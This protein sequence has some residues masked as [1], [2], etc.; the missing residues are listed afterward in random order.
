MLIPRQRRQSQQDAD[1]DHEREHDPERLFRFLAAAR[2]QLG[3]DATEPI[4]L[5]L[6]RMVPRKGV[7]TVIRS[8]ASL[9][10]RAGM[11]LDA[12]V[13]ADTT[14]GKFLATSSRASERWRTRAR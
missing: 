3:W 7:E 10:Q 4:V 14:K 13:P 12:D 1:D 9:R 8:L 11:S 6:G 5:Q 2:R